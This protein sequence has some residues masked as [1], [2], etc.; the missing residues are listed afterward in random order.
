MGLFFSQGEHKCCSVGML[1]KWAYRSQGNKGN[2]GKG[3]FGGYHTW[4]NW[5]S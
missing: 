1:L 5:V 2:G 4:S 3:V